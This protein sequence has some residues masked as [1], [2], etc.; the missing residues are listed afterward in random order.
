MSHDRQALILGRDQDGALEGIVVLEMLGSA[1]RMRAAI[2]RTCADLE[3]RGLAV[4]V[5]LDARRHGLRGKKAHGLHGMQRLL[6]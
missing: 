6:H 5:E 1:K 2:A 4:S 3:R